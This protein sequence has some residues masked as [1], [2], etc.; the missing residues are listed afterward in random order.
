MLIESERRF[1]WCG[2]Q[3]QQFMQIKFVLVRC[4]QSWKEREDMPNLHFV[5][6]SQNL[7]TCEEF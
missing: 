2:E 7:L 3:V 6:V 1:I 5:L 4:F